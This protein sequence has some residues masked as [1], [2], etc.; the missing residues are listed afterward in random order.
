LF[1]SVESDSRGLTTSFHR[2]PG[3]KSAPGEVRDSRL[4]TTT[5]GEGGGGKRKKGEKKREKVLS[6]IKEPLRRYLPRE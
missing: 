5:K 1:E 6:L 2:F 3:G 4:Q